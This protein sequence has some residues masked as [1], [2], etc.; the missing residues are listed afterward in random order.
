MKRIQEYFE[1]NKKKNRVSNGS[2][3]HKIDYK[4]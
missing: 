3:K 1:D 4:N 2:N